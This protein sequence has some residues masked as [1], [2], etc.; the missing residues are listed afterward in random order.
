M[1]N[2]SFRMGTPIVIKSSSVSLDGELFDTPSGRAVAGILPIDTG[3][4]IWGDEFYFR[5]PLDLPLDETATTD[6]HVGDIG[7]WP[8]GQAIAIFFGP[9]PM[10]DGPDPVPASEVNL[11]GRLYGDAREL[12]EAKSAQRLTISRK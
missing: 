1:T 4:N 9:T 5:V 8:A 10:S 12:I 3:F 7:Y 6:V 11:I 2:S